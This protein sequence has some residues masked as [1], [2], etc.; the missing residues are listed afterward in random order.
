MDVF[1]SFWT[2]DALTY[3]ALEVLGFVAL[4][5]VASLANVIRHEGQAGAIAV[6]S[7]KKLLGLTMLGVICAG[8]GAITGN[9]LIMWLSI[10]G[11]S[12]VTLFGVTV[13]ERNNPKELMRRFGAR[14][15]LA[16]IVS[17]VG[18]GVLTVVA[19]QSGAD[20]ARLG[21]ISGMIGVSSVLPAH[22]M[23]YAFALV[24]LGF[25]MTFGVAPMHIGRSELLSK[26]PSPLAALS[27]S[28]GILV[29][30]LSLLRIRFLVDM[31]LND[32][33]AW[34]GNLL[35]VFGVITV[36]CSALALWRIHNYKVWFVDAVMFHTGIVL[37]CMGV[38]LAGT[39]PALMHLAGTVVM[40]AVLFCAAGVLHATFKTTKLPGIRKLF[41]LLPFV[42]STLMVALAGVALLPCSSLFMSGIIAIGYGLQMHFGSTMVVL[43]ATAFA[44]T[45]SIRFGLTFVMQEQEE[46]V[47]L[48]PVHWRLSSLALLVGC[49]ALGVLGWWIGTQAGIK[50]FVSATQLVTS[51]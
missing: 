6:D 27:V 25:G 15:I 32:G 9:V 41:R 2:F 50:F 16:A 23:K 12:V 14:A 1:L 11:L 21:N 3:A 18:I 30:I 24:F 19:V 8:L 36:A 31:V 28:A 35:L 38:G 44:I 4:L 49:V 7:K 39:I 47:A 40:S 34:T 5:S 17:A 13:Y 42:G 46:L 10:T 51:L 20:V 48:T 33:G 22:L 37:T 29:G 26:I 45:A 43:A